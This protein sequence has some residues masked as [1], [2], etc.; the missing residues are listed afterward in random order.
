MKNKYKNRCYKCGDWV[1]PDQGFINRIELCDKKYLVGRLLPKG[2]QW[3]TE[4]SD[5]KTCE[6]RAN[7]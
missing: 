1:E 7:A 2:T 6:E 5:M 3:L 4:C